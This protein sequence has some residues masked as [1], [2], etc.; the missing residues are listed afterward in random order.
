MVGNL[1]EATRSILANYPYD[2]QD[3]R[4]HQL[5]EWLRVNK[6][7]VVRGGDWRAG[8]KSGQTTTRAVDDDDYNPLAVGVRLARRIPVD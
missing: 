6:E 1:W 2:A 5:D 4:E 8:A 7:R 3:G